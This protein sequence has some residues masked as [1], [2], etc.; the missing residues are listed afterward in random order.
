MQFKTSIKGDAC[1]A[2]AS[3]KCRMQHFKGLKTLLWAFALFRLDWGLEVPPKLTPRPKDF[4]SRIITSK[5]VNERL[6]YSGVMKEEANQVHFRKRMVIATSSGACHLAMNANVSSVTHSVLEACGVPKK[7]NDKIDKIIKV[8]V[9]RIKMSELS[10]AEKEEQAKHVLMLHAHYDHLTYTMG[11]RCIFHLKEVVGFMSIWLS[12]YNDHNLNL[13]ED[14][15]FK[16]SQSS[17]L[18][19]QD[20]ARAYLS[21]ME[22]VYDDGR[23]HRVG[24]SNALDPDESRN[25]QY[26]CK[27][28]ARGDWDGFPQ[29]TYPEMPKTSGTDSIDFDLWNTIIAKVA[30]TSFCQPRPKPTP[31]STNSDYIEVE[32]YGSGDYPDSGSGSDYVEG[33][34]SPPNPFPSLSERVYSGPVY[35]DLQWETRAKEGKASGS[36]LFQTLNKRSFESTYSFAPFD[37]ADFKTVPNLTSLNHEPHILHREPRQIFWLIGIGIAL[38]VGS[39][40]YS[41]TQMSD[42]AD[43]ANFNQDVT[44]K[45]LNS[46]DHRM[47]VQEKAVSLLKRSLSKLEEVVNELDTRLAIDEMVMEVNISLE[48]IY[49]EVT[50]IIRGWSAMTN[51]RLSPDFVDMKSLTH[52]LL[53]LRDQMQDQGYVLGL[54]KIENIFTQDMSYILFSNGSLWAFTHLSAY[55]KTNLYTLW[56]FNPI[57]FISTTH[58]GDVALSI[59]PEKKYIGISDDDS[60]HI[61]M[62]QNDLDDCTDVGQ[63]KVCRG[64]SIANT[65]AKAT[66]MSSLFLQD[67]ALIKEHCTWEVTK[68]REFLTQ[69]ESNVFIGYFMERDVMKITCTNG[70]QTESKRQVVEGAVRIVLQGGCKGVTSNHVLEGQLEFSLEAPTYQ[71][72]RLNMTDLLSTPYF[73]ITPD[74][75]ETWHKIIKDVGIAHVPFK[76]VGPLYKRYQSKLS[77]DWGLKTA[78]SI[79]IPILIIMILWFQRNNIKKC[80]TK[81]QERDPRKPDTAQVNFR[82]DDERVDMTVRSNLLHDPSGAASSSTVSPPS[83]TWPERTDPTLVVDMSGATGGRQ[84]ILKTPRTSKKLVDQAGWS[85]EEKDKLMDTAELFMMADLGEEDGARGGDPK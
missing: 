21:S 9:G 14:P 68:K 24:P 80:C 74:Q 13:P 18:M 54:D 61:L 52:K 12:R 31:S 22:Q 81:K 15:K 53:E 20:D 77:L 50:R 29:S 4:G 75:W 60:R 2:V 46:L 10:A 8:A 49:S 42:M 67:M 82:R 19:Q 65:K 58:E 1:N 11:Q 25:W 55:R 23:N 70:K 78:F 66:C 28:R 39:L 38:A 51:Y 72:S 32:E 84:S 33:N 57:P 41:A 47:A 16:I 56:E 36:Q 73:T 34:N 45:Q 7:L 64:Q 43:T 62:D 35:S 5:D 83:T 6:L 3:V 85:R 37:P 79:A 59:L 17:A 48:T 26:W 71:L 30:D 44:I 63:M 69:I 27:L 40:I 76:D